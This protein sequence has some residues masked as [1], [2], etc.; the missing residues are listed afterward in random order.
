[1]IEIRYKVDGEWLT[2]RSITDAAE[3]L[4]DARHPVPARRVDLD[5]AKIENFTS[6]LWAAIRAKRATRS[7]AA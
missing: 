7:E 2:A 4:I 6:A 5:G 3:D 1:M